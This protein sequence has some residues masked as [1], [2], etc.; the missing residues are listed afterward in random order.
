MAAAPEGQCLVSGM[1][2]GGGGGRRR[3]SWF[4]VRALIIP[5]L[6]AAMVLAVCSEGGMLG[7]LEGRGGEGRTGA[8]GIVLYMSGQ[9]ADARNLNHARVWKSSRETEEQGWPKVP[10]KFR[11]PPF[12]NAPDR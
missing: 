8:G 11:V 9:E 3:P 10:G 5:G 1:S 6:V 4:A 12:N 2:G 7:A